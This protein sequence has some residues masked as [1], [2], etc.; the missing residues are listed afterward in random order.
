MY[1]I[2]EEKKI[3]LLPG[4]PS[5]MKFFMES[6]V[7]P[8]IKLISPPRKFYM[9]SVQMFGLPEALIAEKM[10]NVTIK[11]GVNLAYLPQGGSVI[12]RVYGDD[13]AGCDEL[14]SVIKKKFSEN[15]VGVGEL[16]LFASLH[17]KLVDSGLT[18]AMA[19][20]CTGGLFSSSVVNNS[21]SS[22]YFVGGVVS[23]SNE[24][25]RDV[26]GVDEHLLQTKGA[27]SR[28]V[29]EAMARGV[30]TKFGAN[31]AGAIT[32][33]AGPEGGSAEKPVGLVWFAI[34]HKGEV[35]SFSRNLKGDRS[36]IRTFASNFLAGKL[37]VYLNEKMR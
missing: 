2:D 7:L 33:V 25:K 23:Y 37:L 21:G 18:F 14:L 26:L 12:L 35:F 11:N 9:K 5:E 27:V 13:F 4:V 34:F 32:G 31:L 24:I 30:A 1:K 19:E 36:R 28:E 17:N 16:N 10:E 8:E 15:I 22:A 29:A 3:F 20:S 6:L